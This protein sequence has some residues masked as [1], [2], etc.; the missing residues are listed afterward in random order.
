MYSSFYIYIYYLVYTNRKRNKRLLSEALISIYTEVML[1][2]NQR[3]YI[4]IYILFLVTKNN[5]NVSWI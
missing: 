5:V 2:G 4:Y 3:L 1:L